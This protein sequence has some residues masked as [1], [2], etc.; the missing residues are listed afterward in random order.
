[1]S[2]VIFTSI[3]IV[4][5]AS[6]VLFGGNGI[7]VSQPVVYDAETLQDALL[8]LERKLLGVTSIQ[9]ETIT[10]GFAQ[11]Q[12]RIARTNS[13][14]I[15]AG[16]SRGSLDTEGNL[17]PTLTAPAPTI[18]VPTG[19]ADGAGVSLASRDRLSEQITLDHQITNLRL[20]LEQI[21]RTDPNK[22]KVLI[23]FSVSLDP[24]YRK[25]LAEVG[26]SLAK[27]GSSL[28]F[29]LPQK[30]FY[31]VSTMR[32]STRNIG[33]G[34]IAG[35]FPL[36]IGGGSSKEVIYLIKDIDTLALHQKEDD[37]GISFSWRFR[38][39]LGRDTVEP[40]LRNVFALITLPLDVHRS[41]E[42]TFAVKAKWRKWNK[43]RP[44]AGREIGESSDQ[45]RTL[46][47][48]PEPEARELLAPKG[49]SLN[50]FD[51]G[52]DKIRV[53]LVGKNLHTIH[54]ITHGMGR[55]TM[56]EGLITEG[57]RDGLM[58]EAPLGALLDLSGPRARG[59]YAERVL[60]DGGS[61]N[62][63]Q[64]AIAS[65]TVSFIDGQTL[66]VQL[67]VENLSRNP[68]PLV[69]VGKTLFGVGTNPLQRWEE[70][71]KTY[72]AFKASIDMIRQENRFILTVPFSGMKQRVHFQL[73]IPN[74]FSVT[75]AKT[76]VRGGK[77]PQIALFGSGFDKKLHIY[78]GKDQIKS[79]NITIH[80]SSFLIVE[81]PRSTL[82]DADTL[83]LSKKD[84]PLVVVKIDPPAQTPKP[85]FKGTLTLDQGFARR[86]TVEGSNLKSIKEITFD[87]TVLKHEV[88]KEQKLEIVIKPLVTEDSGKKE[89]TVT[90]TDGKKIYLP[91]EVKKAG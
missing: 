19:L 16:E 63:L 17:V 39:T 83:V 27:P 57:N 79:T 62:L 51:I 3:F 15:S 53:T 41:E 81:P 91:F 85:V 31:N 21:Q 8:T 23:G 34:I 61:E 35:V 4:L 77:N 71:S 2:R 46:D 44:I 69:V 86:V 32:K 11:S 76:L 88:T 10:A 20:I 60:R 67:Q 70:D 14:G 38:P 33:L 68:R 90:L 26:I 58:Y 12:G 54:T 25:A 87:D 22:R 65:S 7:V 75:S 48:R 36:G 18:T 84:G 29:M 80:N 13:L 73:K 40:G 82:K 59:S 24:P 6:M 50:W 30:D 55:F 47:L 49:L 5:F 64:L 78:V 72:L 56:A 37:S 52:N 43:N 42:L 45:L 66:R 9:N 89:L 28:D 74:D 1:M